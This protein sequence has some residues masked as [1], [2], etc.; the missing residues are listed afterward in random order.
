MDRQNEAQRL[1]TQVTSGYYA[2]KAWAK[3]YWRE[4]DALTTL[5]APYVVWRTAP[6]QGQMI[7]VDAEGFRVT[8]GATCNDEAFVVF[9][10][11]G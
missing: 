8:P 3:R 9:V 11:G 6:F 7:Q 4:H 2:D 10:L 1:R 5:Y